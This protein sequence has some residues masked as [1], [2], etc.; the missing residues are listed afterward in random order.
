MGSSAQPR[1]QRIDFL[2]WRQ[3]DDIQLW[4]C[5]EAA[6]LCS[7]ELCQVWCGE[8]GGQHCAAMAVARC[9]RHSLHCLSMLISDRGVVAWLLH[10][11]AGCVQSAAGA[12]PP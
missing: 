8:H 1:L 4:F 5:F 6:A 7:Q 11:A 3:L 9:I 12:A 10:D 2:H